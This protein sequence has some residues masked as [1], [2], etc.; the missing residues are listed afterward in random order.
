MKNWQWMSSCRDTKKCNVFSSS[1][2]ESNKTWTCRVI[3][4]LLPIGHAAY[5]EAAKFFG[6]ALKAL[7]LMTLL[8]FISESRD[9]GAT[10][11]SVPTLLFLNFSWT[12]NW[13]WRNNLT[14]NTTWEHNQHSHKTSPSHLCVKSLIC[15][16][17]NRWL[18]SPCR[19]MRLLACEWL[20]LNWNNNLRVICKLVSA[21]AATLSVDAAINEW[22]PCDVL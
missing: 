6:G 7:Q 5:E 15:P 1:G 4:T 16:N 19:P 12:K 20:T 8:I 18:Y 10:N 3:I 14:L 2:E 13:F 11:A 21:T 22:C 17:H 9:G